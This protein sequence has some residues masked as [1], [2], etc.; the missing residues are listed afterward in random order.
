[1]ALREINLVPFETLARR[2]L[3]RH[4]TLWAISATVVFLGILASHMDQE[5][6]LM[7]L[8]HPNSDIAG[9]DRNLASRVEQIR[10]LQADY[11]RLK[12]QQAALENVTAGLSYSKVL[13]RLARAMNEFTWLSSLD[14]DRGKERQGGILLRLTGFSLRNEELGDFLT[15]L[16]RDPLFGQVLLRHVREARVAPSEARAA[17]ESIDGVQFEIECQLLYP[18]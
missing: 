12:V 17:Q 6:R 5:R 11:D 3:G 9:M 4:L 7:A 2:R 15:G 18:G 10:K 1:M 13:F 14:M 8:K 16:S